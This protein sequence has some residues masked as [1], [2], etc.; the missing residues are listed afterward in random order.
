MTT[1]E[2]RALRLGAFRRQIEP[3]SRARDAF[4]AALRD[5]GVPGHGGVLLPAYIGWSPKE[6]SG[7]F[8]PIQGLHAPHAFYRIDRDLRIDLEHLQKQLVQTRPRVLLLIHYFGYPD[9]AFREAVALAREV[10]TLVV[11]DEAHSM[12]SDLIGGICGREGEVALFSLHKLLP[13]SAGGLLVVNSAR[14]ESTDPVLAES[15]PARIP[16]LWEYDLASIAAVRVRNAHFLIKTLA[17]LVEDLDLLR[18]ELPPGV[19][20]QTL[21]IVLKKAPRDEIYTLMNEAGYGVVSLYHTMIAELRAEDCPDAQWLARRILNLPVHQDASIE[22]LA[23]MV[24]YLQQ[25]LTRW[26]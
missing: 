7:V 1:I 24:D 13:V 21:P 26:H 5:M 19:I 10:G 18:P 17:P 8:D 25:L 16:C 15:G 2:K 4:H 9:P 11:E 23:E 12:L 6:G 20:P 3:F 14:W 22:V